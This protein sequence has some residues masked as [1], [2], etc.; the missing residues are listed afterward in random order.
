MKKLKDLC[1]PL[2]EVGRVAYESSIKA[3][4][5]LYAMNEDERSFLA[6]AILYSEPMNILEIGVEAGG[7]SLLMLQLIQ[8]RP[9]TRLV[10][11][12][13]RTHLAAYDGD[14]KN[15]PVGVDAINLL[16]LA[17]ADDH[18]QWTL[19]TGKDPSA[20]I[21]SLATEK[22]DFLVL[23]TAHLL[24]IEVFNFLTVLPFLT[25]NAV[26]VMHDMGQQF[27][28]C[29]SQ[30][31]KLI[32]G[33]KLL[34][35]N[36]IADAKV[37]LEYSEYNNYNPGQMSN[38]VAMQLNAD[39]RKYISNVFSGLNFPWG[40]DPG[41]VIESVTKII[42]KYYGEPDIRIFKN[43]AMRNREIIDNNFMCTPDFDS[44]LRDLEKRFDNY[45][46][47]IIYGLNSMYP[48][49]IYAIFSQLPLPYEIWDN[50][51]DKQEYMGIRV[52]KP[53]LQIPDG[54]PIIIT[55][56]QRKNITHMIRSTPLPL[57][58]NIVV[59]EDYTPYQRLI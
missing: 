54:I 30:F 51:S 9:D 47:Y 43:S 27:L 52:C 46:T 35:D 11:I 16:S 13:I 22:F 23:D 56:K 39:T 21:E 1:V 25:E 31:P 42:S 24:P 14:S 29:F 38:I 10:S 8:N 7:G 55:T 57:R 6:G 17:S 18:P 3:Q 40:L 36:I 59:L 26:M 37:F 45:G 19:I 28:H 58:K 32:L 44:V 41:Y 53:H 33:N 15:A 12:D 34:M 4:Y 48:F 49:Y 50:L 2:E 20:V 5:G